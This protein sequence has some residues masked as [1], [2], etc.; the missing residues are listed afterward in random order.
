MVPDRAVKGPSLPLLDARRTATTRCTYCP[1]LCRPACPVGTAEARETATP[2]GILRALGELTDRPPPEDLA[3][4]AATA[5]SCTGCGGCGTLCLL[6]NPVTETIWDARRDAH[7]A[8]LA[9]PSVTAFREG[10]DAR[11]RR[12]PRPEGLAEVPAGDGRT[13]FVP[14]C[15]MVARE[16]DAVAPGA[17]AVAAL[18]G[19]ARVLTDVCCGAPLLDAG[20]EEGFLR[21]AR[22]FLDAVGDA[23]DLVLA[24]A[25]CAHTL[26]TAYAQRGLFPA[27][28]RRAEHVSELASRKLHRLRAVGDPRAVIVHDA[29]RLGRGLGVYDAPRAVL[30]ALLGAPPRELPEHHDHGRCSGGGGLYPVTN[31]AGATAVAQDLASLAREVAGDDPAVVV[32]SCPTS[33]AK[34]RAA[35][36]DSEDLLA[37][38]ARGLTP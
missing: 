27:R 9:P 1:K 37:W 26:R 24:D 34:L 5:W 38:I 25:G 11:L 13:V 19:G 17:H 10:F 20:D 18:T 15:S 30:H 28:W 16:T 22:R 35:G 14:G 7:A 6:H 3:S 8:G 29:C 2:W 36:I 23:E 31:P 33:R 12:L 32:T 21:A 4:H